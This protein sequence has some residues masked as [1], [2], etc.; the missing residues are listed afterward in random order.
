VADLP[1]QDHGGTGLLRIQAFE[2][3]P[4]CGFLSLDINLQPGA[5][6]EYP[7]CQIQFNGKIVNKRPETDA[8][9]CAG[10]TNA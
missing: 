7:T 9:D 6:I 2:E 10:E 3:S 1:G 5:G 8:L 4:N